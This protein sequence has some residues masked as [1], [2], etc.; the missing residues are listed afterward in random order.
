MAQL[1]QL[2]ETIPQTV[3]QVNPAMAAGLSMGLHPI[4]TTTGAAQG[5]FNS[6][7][8]GAQGMARGGQMIAQGATNPNLSAMQRLGLVGG[9]AAAAGREAA[10]I[11][12]SLV[13]DPLSRIP[14][15][16]GMARG[17]MTPV[18]FMDVNIRK[19][20]GQEKYPAPGMEKVMEPAEG[21]TGWL[22][23]LAGQEVPM[24]EA[25]IPEGGAFGE[26]G[27]K[28]FPS[29]PMR[30]VSQGASEF[31]NTMGVPV[32]DTATRI[33]FM[34]LLS[35]AKKIG[36]QEQKYIPQQDLGL[37][38]KRNKQDMQT[39]RRLWGEA[40]DEMAKSND[41]Y[42]RHPEEV[43]PA[44]I[45]PLS[46]TDYEQK[47]GDYN[48]SL[49][50]NASRNAL[51]P[52]LEAANRSIGDDIT[53]G[54][55]K[56]IDLIKIQQDQAIERSRV[57][58]YRKPVFGDVQGTSLAGELSGDDSVTYDNLV[59]AYGPPNMENDGYK[60]DAE[61][62]VST[63]EGVVTIYNYKTGKNYLRD[64]GLD[65]NDI[66]EWNLGAR[67]KAAADYVIEDLRARGAI[68]GPKRTGTK[69]NVDLE[70][71][72]KRS[73]DDSAGGS[74]QLA[75]AGKKFYW[76]VG[77]EEGGAHAAPTWVKKQIDFA[78]DEYVKDF[79]KIRDSSEA[80]EEI[81]M[82]L[83]EDPD[84]AEWVDNKGFV[85]NGALEWQDDIA[86]Y[87]DSRLL[88]DD[89]ARQNPTLEVYKSPTTSWKNAQA[90]GRTLGDAST[91]RTP[92]PTV[93]PAL[94]KIA[95]ERPLIIFANPKDGKGGMVF[96]QSD[97]DEAGPLYSP[98]SRHV[99]PTY[100]D[101]V[102][103]AQKL[104]A[105]EVKVFNEE[106]GKWED[107]DFSSRP[108]TPDLESPTKRSLDDGAGE[109]YRPAM[110]KN[111]IT[112]TK[113]NGEDKSWSMKQVDKLMA[114]TS[115]GFEFRVPKDVA[116]W[117]WDYIDTL[118]AQ[119]KIKSIGDNTDKDGYTRS[120]SY[121]VVKKR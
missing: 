64:E 66:T 3:A 90:A 118:E 39:S 13:L 109:A 26:A 57:K 36:E 94:Q 35:M 55:P 80:A 81:A 31:M 82:N 21:P 84:I 38:A 24:K 4:R 91:T 115:K 108:P 61:W 41:Y 78:I 54:K 104:G 99:F 27:R 96:R 22:K 111:K 63:P 101:A 93:T 119:G 47:Y 16:Q 7:M 112:P 65:V 40:Q 48:R 9:G 77:D 114:K 51:T 120:Y 69:I 97:S 50:D 121:E 102:A 106:S 23:Q 117:C 58:P 107:K 18:N 60:T 11:A 92:E 12:P 2:R 19:L 29:G 89:P 28:L 32:M 105:P 52:D 88:P 6:A 76:S 62:V 100:E 43:K 75:P 1:N 30:D 53:R 59:K 15:T 10:W 70:S 87:I 56:D 98:L 49:V 5:L 46:E 33:G 83:A 116:V 67:S 72:T 79:G 34:K 95:K 103:F 74:G 73:L 42:A 71:P 68:R 113:F 45:V 37:M 44:P 17:M 85:T 20:Y 110:A 8:Q 14:E 25:Q 86:A